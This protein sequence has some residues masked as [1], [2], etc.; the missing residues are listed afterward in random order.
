[1]TM[2]VDAW[3]QALREAGFA[4][5]EVDGPLVFA[6]AAGGLEFTL[7][8][9]PDARLSLRFPVRASDGDMRVW[10]AANPPGT[11]ALQAGEVELSLPLTRPVDL[12]PWPALVHSAERAAAQW[13]RGLRPLS[14]M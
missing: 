2:T 7:T 6:R 9:G 11:M 4:G 14:G 13:R 3:A 12:A 10:M 8:P 5:V 1:M